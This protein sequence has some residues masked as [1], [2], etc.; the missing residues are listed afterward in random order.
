[1]EVN[2]ASLAGLNTSFNTIFNGVLGGIKPTWQTIAMQVPSTTRENDY[3]WLGKLKGM[4]E[5]IGDRV[6]ENVAKDGYKVTNRKFENTVGVSRDDIEDDQIGVYNPLVADLAQTAGEHPDY[7]VWEL[8][9]AGFTTACFDG[10]NFFDTDHPVIG[11]DGAEI[12]VSNFAGGAGTPWFLLDTS[13]AIKPMIFQLRR[14]AKLTSLTNM[15]DPNVFMRDEYLWGVDM[16]AA[17]GFGLWQLAY[18]SKQELT[19]DNYMAAR[20][21]MQDMKG[22]HGRQLRLKPM[23]LVVPGVLEKK[24]LEVLKAERDAAGATNVAAGTA[25]L[26]VE[27][28]LAA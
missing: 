14:A 20:A 10:Q 13:R 16:R 18:A 21:A 27:T 15:D 8:F 11:A 9:K 1:M 25:T 6:I 7:L 5:W 2:R 26:H 17:A 12:S 19:S 4:R 24:G 28:L 3:R 23:I 22:D